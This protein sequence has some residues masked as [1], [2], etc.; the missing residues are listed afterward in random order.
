MT[1][2]IVG[3]LGVLLFGAGVFTGVALT[4]RFAHVLVARLTPAQKLAFARKV[5]RAAKS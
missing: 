4:G 2:L 5:N 3:V 1:V